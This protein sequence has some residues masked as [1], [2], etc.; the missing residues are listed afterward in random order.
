M[1][2]LGNPPFFKIPVT[3]LVAG[4]AS[5]VPLLPQTACVGEEPSAILSF[6]AFLSLI[7]SL[8]AGI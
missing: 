6:E 2:L 5:P 4:D 1:C 7:S 3:C 8:L